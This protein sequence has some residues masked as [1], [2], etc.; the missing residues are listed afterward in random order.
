MIHEKTAF[1]LRL[2]RTISIGLHPQSL[3][4]NTSESYPIV[5]EKLLPMSPSR[6]LPLSP[7]RTKG[8]KGDL[9]VT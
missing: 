1:T 7:V 4:A 3:P 6:L 8:V 5:Y 9:G 2:L